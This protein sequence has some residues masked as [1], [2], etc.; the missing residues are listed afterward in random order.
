MLRLLILLLLITGINMLASHL[1]LPYLAIASTDGA[2]FIFDTKAAVL[3][4]S[5]ETLNWN[6]VCL[7]DSVISECVLDINSA[8]WLDPP[9]LKVGHSTNAVSSLTFHPTQPLLLISNSAGELINVHIPTS[10]VLGNK[11]K[12][13]PSFIISTEYHPFLPYVSC[14]RRMANDSTTIEILD[15]TSSQLSLVHSQTFDSALSRPKSNQSKNRD[16]ILSFHSK[17]N[18]GAISDEEGNIRIFNLH[19]NPNDSNFSLIPVSPGKT[20][21][22]FCM[23]LCTF[24]LLFLYLISLSFTHI[25]TLSLSLT[26]FTLSLSLSFS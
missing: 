7:V 8:K 18:Y 24:F 17:L 6:L 1:F 9:T 19:L 2:V 15:F 23:C 12:T 11:L 5:K 14:L 25:P 26:H 4:W 10:R 21:K 16:K 22:P 13:S 20:P 3:D